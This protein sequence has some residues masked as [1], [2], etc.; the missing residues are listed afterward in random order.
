VGMAQ[1]KPIDESSMLEVS[2]VGNVK[3]ERFG[4]DF[5]K[6]IQENTLSSIKKP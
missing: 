4:E 3:F 6:I 1:L 5:L 2:G